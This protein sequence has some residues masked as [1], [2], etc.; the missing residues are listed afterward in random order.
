MQEVLDPKALLREANLAGNRVAVCVLAHASPS[1]AAPRSQPSAEAPDVPTSREREGGGEPSEHNRH[2]LMIRTSGSVCQT[3]ELYELCG[4][5]PET[6]CIHM[7][8]C[9]IRSACDRFEAVM[10][11]CTTGIAPAAVTEHCQSCCL[12]V[13]RL[14]DFPCFHIRRSSPR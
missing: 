3:L 7:Q 12:S 10:V 13:S 1:I 2:V 8:V 9:P 14:H 5:G 4:S 11:P 6:A